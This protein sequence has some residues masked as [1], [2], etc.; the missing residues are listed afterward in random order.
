MVVRRLSRRAKAAAARVF[1]IPELRFFICRSDSLEH[2]DLYCLAL[3]SRDWA[4]V[5]GHVLWESPL[6]V[7]PLFIH[8]PR[9]S[10]EV[11]NLEQRQTPFASYQSWQT[12]KAFRFTRA[13]TDADWEPVLARA[14]TV[15]HITLLAFP[16][17]VMQ[18]LYAHPPPRTLFPNLRSVNI[19]GIEPPLPPAF[20]DIILPR[21]LVVYETFDFGK[22]TLP[23][24]RD[25]PC[26]RALLLRNT[27][28]TMA[29][30]AVK[31][32]V[33]IVKTSS[34]L[35]RVELPVGPYPELISSL[36]AHPTL[37]TLYLDTVGTG[38]LP[39][40]LAPGSFSTLT[41]VQADGH[42]SLAFVIGILDASP[43]VRL[44][45]RITVVSSPTEARQ[46]PSLLR[47][48]SNHC[49][50]F[51][52][53]SLRVIASRNSLYDEDDGVPL[54]QD[55]IRM[56]DLAPLARFADVETLE[57]ETSQG[58]ALSDADCAT[59]SS[60]W[61]HLRGLNLSRPGRFRSDQ[62]TPTCTLRAVADVA[63]L[64]PDLEILVLPIDARAIPDILIS[65]QCKLTVLKALDS[66][67]VD[68]PAVASFLS[69]L[70]PELYIL[71]YDDGYLPPDSDSE[72]EH[73]VLVQDPD[74]PDAQRRRAW[75]TVREI[76]EVRSE[77]H[78]SD[79]EY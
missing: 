30:A 64:C 55:A 28:N 61:P 19:S 52:L 16:L 56:G 50:P 29:P 22:I 54:P 49:D 73:E 47:A 8:M 62:D 36:A 1:A 44:M 12:M 51:V 23:H 67:I 76:M 63:R 34:S 53:R 65:P 43:A 31:Q 17:P 58:H 57:I 26:L 66:L 59:I 2:S 33:E 27:S 60:W 20:L 35:R 10:W 40:P 78:D 4:P 13:L 3:V 18:V 9:D 15:K 79:I 38:S 42:S 24:R 39:S 41:R 70:F 74:A 7:L 5:A 46:I 75:A 6:G 45:E 32:A 21:E 11:P 48:I 77:A 71:M 14:R 72:G 69:S 68:P 25:W 37:H